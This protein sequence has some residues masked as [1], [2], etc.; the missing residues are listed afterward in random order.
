MLP[1]LTLE[2]ALQDPHRRSKGPT[3]RSHMH[4]H[5]HT[6]AGNK[7]EMASSPVLWGMDRELP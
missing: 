1:S 4:H 5:M 3:P 2:F 6:E 7:L